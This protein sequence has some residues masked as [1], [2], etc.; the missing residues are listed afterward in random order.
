ESML[1]GEPKPYKIY[2]TVDPGFISIAAVD[3]AKN[4]YTGFE[5][6]HFD[7]L[8][9]EDQIAKKIAGLTQQ[10]SLLKKVD[11]RNVSILFAGSRFTF[12]PSAFFKEEDAKDFFYCNLT[13]AEGETFHSH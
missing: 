5:G 10:S 13:S 12:I 11:F 3:P 8:L 7:K 9:T 6:Y 4:K 2:C 1:T